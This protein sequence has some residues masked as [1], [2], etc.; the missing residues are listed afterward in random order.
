MPIHPIVVHV[1]L[2]LAGLTPLVAG[3]LAWQTWR[4]KGSRRAWLVAFALQ[5]VIVGSALVAIDTGGDEADVVRKVVPHGVIGAHAHAA[6]QFTIGAGAVAAM[7]LAAVVFTDKKA[8]VAGG[9]AAAAAVF[10]VVLGLRAGHAG[11]KL[12]FQYDAGAAYVK[13]PGTGTTAGRE[14]PPG[15]AAP[16]PV[17]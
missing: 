2:V 15:A 1:P 14:P 6:R 10:V 3:W 16:A 5:A 13:V 8:A 17:P 4:G 7:L 9:V 12:V 11:G